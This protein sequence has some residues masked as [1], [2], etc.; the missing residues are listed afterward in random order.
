MGRFSRKKVVERLEPVE[1][2][3]TE[4]QMKEMHE[5]IEGPVK[6]RFDMLEK[7]TKDAVVSLE[8]MW[9]IMEKAVTIHEYL[10]YPKDYYDKEL[11]GKPRKVT[12][13]V[14]QVNENNDIIHSPW[15]RLRKKWKAYQDWLSRR[16]I[17]KRINLEH[18]EETV[19]RAINPKK[20]S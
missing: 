6:K 1:E 12:K 14:V 9:Y 18:I 3:W 5:L 16:E 20:R 13:I 4:Q 11:A 10:A 2:H 7:S 8:T 15:E 19:G 17:P